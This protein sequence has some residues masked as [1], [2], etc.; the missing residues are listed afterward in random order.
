MA[1]DDH[2][3]PLLRQVGSKVASLDKPRSSRA[4][5]IKWRVKSSPLERIRESSRAFHGLGRRSRA[6]AS[7]QK[8]PDIRQVYE[9]LL[10]RPTSHP[11]ARDS[12]EGL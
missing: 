4:A 10:V 1:I 3:I 5:S 6:P 12:Y 2:S 8:S 9:T 7:M 11:A